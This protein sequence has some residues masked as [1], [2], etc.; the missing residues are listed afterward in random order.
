MMLCQCP[1]LLY[2]GNMFIYSIM[3][4]QWKY[5]N[6]Y[7]KSTLYS[8][9]T[10]QGKT[11][12]GIIWMSFSLPLCKPTD[13]P[14]A[15]DLIEAEIDDLMSPATE[16]WC[17]DYCQ[18]LRSTWL[19]GNFA[20]EEWNYWDRMEEGHLTNNACEGLNNRLRRRMGSDHPSFY[21][22][23]G[24]IQKELLNSRNKMEQVLSGTIQQHKTGRTLMLE[25]SRKKLKDLYEN[26]QITLRKYLRAMG[27]LSGKV[28]SI[29]SRSRNQQ[30]PGAEVRGVGTDGAVG[31]G[32]NDAPADRL[33]RG[34]LLSI[35]N[36]TVDE[37]PVQ[38]RH[39]RVG[40]GAHRAGGIR[41]RG[42]APTHRQCPGCGGTYR[43]NY[44]RQHQNR[45][46]PGPREDDGQLEQEDD[47]ETIEV[48]GRLIDVE[49]LMRQIREE[50]DNDDGF[51]VEDILGEVIELDQTLRGE[52]TRRS[53]RFN[54]IEEE[55]ESEA[56]H[57]LL[58]LAQQRL[59]GER[60]RPS[61]SDSPP[62]SRR[63]LQSDPDGD[64]VS[65]YQIQLGPQLTLR[66]T[67]PTQEDI[68][69]P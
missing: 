45:H 42:A 62:S 40:G 9:D 33:V 22:F 57:V 55:E 61:D 64:A 43:S 24:V 12:K 60:R 16:A 65:Q 36:D 37:A 51:D 47:D 59:Q 21:K 48:G 28:H 10:V 26:R 56:R 1:G 44:I 66:P 14:A 68:G 35:T 31:L 27:A 52:R 15:M 53:G 25:K 23:A 39:G 32:T 20:I 19:E 29:H 2:G 5:V 50:D 17:R 30:L 6:K 4:N 63:R 34:A 11:F 18:Y 46:C 67:V 8:S 69:K 58:H 49:E 13:I 41:G 3:Q 54:H 38:R 7:G